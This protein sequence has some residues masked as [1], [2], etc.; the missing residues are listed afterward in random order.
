MRRCD[1]AVVFKYSVFNAV[2]AAATGALYWQLNDIAPYVSWSGYDSGGVHQIQA[3]SSLSRSVLDNS[4]VSIL[5]SAILRL[6]RI[7]GAMC[8]GH[9]MLPPPGASF[10]HPASYRLGNASQ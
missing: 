8:P 10:T 1:P 9:T 6:L 7:C 2:A 4:A 3:T 5:R